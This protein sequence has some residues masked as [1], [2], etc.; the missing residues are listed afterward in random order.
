M[1]SA[2]P[3]TVQTDHIDWGFRVSALYGENYRYTTAYGI[4]S[5]QLLKH[6]LVNGYDFPMMYGEVYIPQVAE[7]LLIRV[8]RYISIP[9]SRRSSRRTTTCTRT[10]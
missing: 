5:Y 2:V 4:A 6:N 7:G 8:G 10:R 3:D 1:P 9:T